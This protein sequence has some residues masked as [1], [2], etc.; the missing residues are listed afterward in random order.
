VA[1]TTAARLERDGTNGGFRL[2]VE[3]G[4]VDCS[5]PCFQ[6]ACVAVTSSGA[7]QGRAQTLDS[8]SP[9][10]QVFNNADNVLY[11]QCSFGLAFADNVSEQTSVQLQRDATSESGWR[12]LL[13]STTNQ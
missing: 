4:Q 8:E 11:F 9:P 5:G 10:I 13:I 1:R 7:V 12:G 3:P 6:I 2:A